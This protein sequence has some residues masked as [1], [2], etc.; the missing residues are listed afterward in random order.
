MKLFQRFL[1]LASVL[2]L[3]SFPL[4]AQTTGTLTGSVTL[5]GEPLPGVTV[6]ITSPSLQGT[7]VAVTDANGNYQFPALPPG[8][9]NV[10][11]NMEGMN[12]VT[13]NVRVSVASTSRADAIM[14]LS[15]VA[16]EITVTA[17]APAVLETQ[18]IQTNIQEE[19]VEALPLGRDIL[20]T[21][22][23]AAGV[24]NNGPGGN[25]TISGAMSYDSIYNVDGVVVNE[26]L[27]G[28]PQTVFIEDAIQETTVLTGAISA[29][30]GRFTGGVV[31]TVTKSGGNEFEGSLRA[32]LTNP[33]W[34]DTTPFGEAEADSEL[35]ETY[36]ATLGGR[37][38]RDRL[39]FFT[40]G[41]YFETSAQR[42]LSRSAIDFTTGQE[43]TRLQG[44][45]TGQITPRHSLVGTYTDVTDD[46]TNYSFGTSAEF[47]AIDPVR[48]VPQ[49]QFSIIYNGILTDNFLIEANYAEKNLEF[50]GSG[51]EPGDFA[52][53]TNVLIVPWGSWAGAPVFGT[54]GGV[55]ERPSENWTIKGN[56]FLSTSGMGTHNIVAGYDDYTDS[57][58]ANNHQSGSDFTVYLYDE[59]TR[60]EGTLLPVVNPGNALIIYWPI[61]Q[62]SLGSDFNT[63][64]FFVNDKWDLNQNLSFNLG[65]RYDA[66]EGTDEAG[67]KVADDS[68]VSPRLGATYDVFGDGRLRFGATYSEYSTK[69]SNG[70]VGNAASP[71]GSPSLLYWYYG[72]PAISGMTTTETLSAM[73][74]W[75]QSIGG[76]NSTDTP[77]FLGGSTNGVS[78]VILDE[79]ESPGVDE[80]T[81]GVGTQ[82]GAN[83]F[84]RLDYQNREWNNFYT[85]RVDLGTGSVLDPLAGVELDISVTE[86]SDDFTR[87]YN[88]VLVQAGYRLFNRLNLGANYTWSELEGNYVGETS[89]SGPVSVAGNNYY[90]EYLGYAQRN[91]VGPLPQDQEHRLRAW[92]SYDLPTPIGNFNFSLLQNFDSGA[93][94]S[95][96]GSI[97]VHQ[98]AAC[99]QCLPNPG[100]KNIPVGNTY[101]FSER[102]EFR[103]E[104]VSR[105][106]FALNYALPIGPVN[107]FV[108]G[109]VFNLFN[110]D[111]IVGFDTTILTARSAACV[112]NVGP[113]AGQRCAAFNPFTEQPV[114]G[115]HWRRGSRFGNPTGPGS[116]QTPRTYRV[117]A[118]IRF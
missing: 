93:P 115:V 116:Y 83:G 69:V 86:N 62:S 72:G 79:L 40:A 38:I 84:V 28:Q 27:R 82:L 114:E 94:Y 34:T 104:D 64:S 97:D 102:G 39:W 90:P 67:A 48:S 50:V 70:N 44:K 21:V 59:P 26:V 42:F 12:D 31:N 105:T 16:Q 36:E 9:Y 63:T 3:V 73:W 45:L 37:I 13:Q 103:T 61:L 77:F 57:I 56:Y 6:T 1:V 17:S 107:L 66:N 43:Q 74:D 11:F 15:A 110:E 51:S 85:G 117:S 54:Q 5:D 99:P 8:N 91:P 118:G 47:S 109:E 19:L 87:E 96:A 76:L 78:S 52:N 112:Q 35:N 75:F 32:N 30:F 33:A 98:R 7:R 4:V 88:A 108:Q 53:A 81:V 10:R 111:E 60:A 20:S 41:R 113:N 92:A 80:W 68:R 22:S 2:L 58:R 23:L 49:E 29:E 95:L 89:G 14:Q 25:Q 100:Y 101:Y 65:A 24:N 55:S 46:Q 18:E 71:A 106:D